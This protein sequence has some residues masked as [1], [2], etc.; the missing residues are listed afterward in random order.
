MR[1]REKGLGWGK[2][3]RERVFFFFFFFFLD[4]V[5]CNCEGRINYTSLDARIAF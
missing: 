3:G 5:V 2:E 1:A 4:G